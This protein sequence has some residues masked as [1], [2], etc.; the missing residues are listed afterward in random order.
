MP[1]GVGCAPRRGGGCV[2][3]HQPPTPGDA[4]GVSGR[5]CSWRGENPAGKPQR[6]RTALTASAGRRSQRQI[7]KANL[8]E[9]VLVSVFRPV[10]RRG[11]VRLLRRGCTD[12][13]PAG[14]GLRHRAGGSCPRG[15]A[16][17]RSKPGFFQEVAWVF[18]FLLAYFYK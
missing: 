15:L 6:L 1:R 2:P 7:L 17:E 9:S 18:V 3:R 8:W 5:T 13:A 11:V 4:L 10:P 14:A 16:G 12:T